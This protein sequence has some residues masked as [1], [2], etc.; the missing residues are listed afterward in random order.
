MV[1]L[2]LGHAFRIRQR[3]RIRANRYKQS[4]VTSPRWFI[5]RIHFHHD[6]QS[7]FRLH[8]QRY[9]PTN[10]QLFLKGEHFL[11]EPKWFELPATEAAALGS[12]WFESLSDTNQTRSEGT[13]Q[14]K[15][16]RS[17]LQKVYKYALVYCEFPYSVLLPI[18]HLT[19]SSI[20]RLPG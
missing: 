3:L 14:S 18:F 16:I 12:G 15:L 8:Y 17:D 11:L 10:T 2:H 6:T 13:P 7:A 9:L 19:Y 4:N 1:F 5:L 20:S